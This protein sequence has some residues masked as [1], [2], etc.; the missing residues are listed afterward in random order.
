MHSSYV[1]SEGSHCLFYG[2]F[3]KKINCRVC[4]GWFPVYVYFKFGV[5]A[6]YC[7]IEKGYGIVFFVC[8]VKFY[9][10]VHFIYICVHGVQHKHNYRFCV[11]TSLLW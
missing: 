4:S 8:G 6:C 11:K 5:S 3:R 2:V 9:V 10:I 7:L 1:K